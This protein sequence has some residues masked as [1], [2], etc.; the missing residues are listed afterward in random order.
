MRKTRL[1]AAVLGSI[2][3]LTL[4]PLAAQI[5]FADPASCSKG[6]PTI[7]AG[8]GSQL[9]GQGSGYCSNSGV[10]RT[11]TVEIKWNKNLAPDPLVAKNSTSG[12]KNNYAVT[13]TSCD[14]GNTRGYYSRDYFSQTVSDHKDSDPRTL[15]AC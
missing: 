15:T 2:V 7:D 4:S 14:S 3:A 1:T 6:T 13:T 5:A 11:F 8:L 9:I 12:A 10:Y